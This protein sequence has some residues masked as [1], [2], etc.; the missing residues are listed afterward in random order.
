MKFRHST[1]YLILSMILCSMTAIAQ[2]QMPSKEDRIRWM[3][4]MRQYKAEY[5][6]KDLN[7][8]DE[9]KQKFVPLY[10]KLD[11]ET[12]HLGFETRQLEYSVMHKG[13]KASDLEYEKAAE[14][15]FELKSKESAIELKYFD[16]FKSI[17]TKQQLFKLKGAERKFTQ[18]L[19]KHH[20][21][22][23][24]RKKKRPND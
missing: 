12:S 9:Q 11:A 8:T 3:K 7:L 16:D 14:A 17:L 18:E 21:K 5:I 20:R 19:M 1:I 4:E 23:A 2:K 6:A 10:E 15:L 13:D 22:S 24:G